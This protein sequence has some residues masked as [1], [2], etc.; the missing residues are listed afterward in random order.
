[1][2]SLLAEVYVNRH[3]RADLTPGT[4]RNVRLNN[5]TIRISGTNLTAVLHCGLTVQCAL[6][7]KS[8]SLQTLVTPGYEGRL[9]GKSFRELGDENL[10]QIEMEQSLH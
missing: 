10:D 4:V 9:T 6:L 3:L 1:M 2:N 5:A 8:L 7:Q